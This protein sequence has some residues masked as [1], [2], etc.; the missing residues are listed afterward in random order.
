LQ[1]TTATYPLT[2][3]FNCLYLRINGKNPAK[4][5]SP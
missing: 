4:T 3:A 5:S 2:S 1:S